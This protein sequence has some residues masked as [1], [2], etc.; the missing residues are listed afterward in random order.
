MVQFDNPLCVMIRDG[1]SYD[2]PVELKIIED[3]EIYETRMTVQL[4]D[5]FVMFSDGVP[6]AGIGIT[7]SLGWQQEN[8][9]KFLEENYRYLTKI[10]PTIPTRGFFFV[11]S[12]SISSNSFTI[13]RMFFL[14]S[15]CFG[16]FT[17]SI[18]TFFH[19]S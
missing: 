16:F 12:N 6:H 5:S 15:D 13:C 4:D 18:Q 1:K 7:M 10:S 19:L 3:K 14:S 11:S 9:R 2:Y 17:A 8:V